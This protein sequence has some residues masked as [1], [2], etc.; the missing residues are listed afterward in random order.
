MQKRRAG[1]LLHLTSL[2]GK[3][4]IGTLGKEAYAFVDFLV[5]AKQTYWQILPL[6]PTGY[7]DSPYQCF[8]SKAGNPY[9][10]D[11][12]NLCELQLLNEE[13]LFVDENFSNDKVIY[14]I[15]IETKLALLKKAQVNFKADENLILKTQFDNYCVNNNQWLDDYALFMALKEK[16]ENKPWYEWS[17]DYRLLNV[18]TLNNVKPELEDTIHFHKFIQ[19]LFSQQWFSLKQYAN[20][21]E[22]LIIGD[23]PIYV[24][25]DSS[26]TWMNPQL[27]QFDENK[28]PLCVGGCP[29]DYFSET[30]QLWGNPIFDYAEMETDNF[31]WWIDRIKTT[32][33]L[34]DLVRVDHFRGFAGYWRIP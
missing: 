1:I 20:E 8:S 17:D 3:F 25:M 31:S 13:D 14:G 4:G 16:F 28:N 21:K 9:L 19:F 26:D 15:V 5:A 11:L 29:P 34:Y 32:L 6:G 12:D 10:I 30:G 23:I 27:F 18:E 2:P 22:I 7:G 24:A 33:T